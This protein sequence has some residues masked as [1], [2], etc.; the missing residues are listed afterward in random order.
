[1]GDT[2]VD[3]AISRMGNTMTRMHL[4][5]AATVILYSSKRWST[6]RAWGVR[7]AKRRGFNVARIAL[8]RKL[9][10]IL[11]RMWITEQDFRWTTGAEPAN[12]DKSPPDECMAVGS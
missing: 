3:G 1:M 5:Q 12:N 6:L 4:V 2:D 11:H 8:A 9:A 7:V 10:I